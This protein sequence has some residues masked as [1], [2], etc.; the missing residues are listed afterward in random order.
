LKSECYPPAKNQDFLRIPQSIVHTSGRSG[1][2]A[3]TDI[4][5]PPEPLQRHEVRSSSFT[6][7]L[8]KRSPPAQATVTPVE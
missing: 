8:L 1:C 3:V 7:P 4:S 6:P 2:V 5:S